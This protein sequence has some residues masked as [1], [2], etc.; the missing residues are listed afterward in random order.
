ME[1]K[2]FSEEVIKD[3]MT[4]HPELTRKYIIN[5]HKEIYDSITDEM[6]YDFMDGKSDWDFNTAKRFL[7]SIKE[8]K[9]NLT[10]D[11]KLVMDRLRKSL[12]KG[13]KK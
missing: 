7:I 10:M 12:K 2:P 6:V 3:I 4:T 1:F 5:K 9:A 8:A 11:S 13:F